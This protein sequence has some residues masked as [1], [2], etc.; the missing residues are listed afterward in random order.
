MAAE[1]RIELPTYR[2]WILQGSMIPNKINLTRQSP[3][4]PGKFCNPAQPRC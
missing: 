3:A 1:D 2:L 4:I